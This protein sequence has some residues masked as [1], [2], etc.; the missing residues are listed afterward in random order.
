MGIGH[1]RENFQGCCLPQRGYIHTSSYKLLL[2]RVIQVIFIERSGHLLSIMKH[3]QSHTSRPQPGTDV[4][5][6][7]KKYFRQKNRRKNWRC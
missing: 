3:G 1:S 7:F 5:Y 2:V 4:M 6:D